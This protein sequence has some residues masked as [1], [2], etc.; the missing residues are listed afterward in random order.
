PAVGAGERVP[1]ELLGAFAVQQRGVVVPDRADEHADAGPAAGGGRDAGVLQRLPAQFQDEPLLGVDGG[2]LARRDPEERGVEPV[3]RVEEGA[4]AGGHA[5]GGVGVGGVEVVGVP[6]VGGGVAHGLASAAQQ[7]PQRGGVGGAGEAA[8]QADDGDAVGLSAGT[9]GTGGRGHGT[10]VSPTVFHRFPDPHRSARRSARD[11]SSA[12]RG[13]LARWSAV[14]RR[15]IPYSLRK[16]FAPVFLRVRPGACGSGV[17]WPWHSVITATGRYG[18][19]G[20]RTT[21]N[22]AIPV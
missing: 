16:E 7:V 17:P 2:G 21:P 13:I 14:P 15:G 12:I 18:F 8:G 19:A 20:G 10:L 22:Q 11:R 1:V 6:A 3:D 5:A 9:G 4:A